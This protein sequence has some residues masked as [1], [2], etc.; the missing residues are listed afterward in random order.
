VRLAALGGV[1]FFVLIVIQANL[2]TGSPSATDSG[3]EI[4]DYLAS[5]R[6]RL[7]IGA[8]LLGFAMPAV[9]LWLS[10]LFRALRTVEGGNP[11]LAVAAF[12]GG[13]LAAASTVVGALIEGTMAARIHDLG[14]ADAA[15]WWTM[16]LL[17]TGA[18]LLGLLLLIGATAIVCLRRN[19]FGRRFAVATVVLALATAVGACTI[20]YATS[21]IQTVAGIAVLLDSVWILVVS[22]FLWRDPAVALP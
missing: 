15:V 14:A 13:V 18:T 1:L 2:R 20:G 11:R 16:F 4:L 19:L 3:Q 21:G 12:A 8:V 5:H 17:S 6:R 9:L 7:Q 22:I 10:G